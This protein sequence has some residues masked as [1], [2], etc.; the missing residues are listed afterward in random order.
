MKLFCFG[1][2]GKPVTAKLSEVLFINSHYLI[3]TNKKRTKIKGSEYNG[4]I[5]TYFKRAN[6]DVIS[7]IVFHAEVETNKGM[8]LVNY[9]IRDNDLEGIENVQFNDSIG[10][11]IVNL[12]KNKRKK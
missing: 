8:T 7:G 9:I 6:I 4:F 5:K 10:L 2:S 12:P 1:L 3:E 11:K